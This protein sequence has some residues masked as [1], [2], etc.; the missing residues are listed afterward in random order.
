M[1][2]VKNA[3]VACQSNYN[4]LCVLNERAQIELNL[5]FLGFWLLK[6]IM[7]EIEKEIDIEE[8]EPELLD[9]EESSNY[10][11][12]DKQDMS[13]REDLLDAKFGFARFTEGVDKTAWL[14]NVKPVSFSF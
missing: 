4:C 13:R 6:F 9:D 11:G 7:E 3:M 8:E 12:G 2:I 14:F 10:L 5:Y 1:I